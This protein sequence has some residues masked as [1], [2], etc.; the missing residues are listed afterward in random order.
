[1]T[2]TESKAHRR[3]RFWS[4]VL[5]TLALV[6]AG[7]V[8]TVPAHAADGDYVGQVV[9]GTDNSTWETYGGTRIL[10]KMVTD[11]PYNALITGPQFGGG[12]A[13]YNWSIEEG[14]L[15]TGLFYSGENTPSVTI[16]GTPEEAEEFEFVLV[17]DEGEVRYRLQ[18]SGSVESGKIAT[19]TTVDSVD[20]HSA[21]SVSFSA[22]VIAADSSEI[23]GGTVQFALSGMPIGGPVAVA[24]GGVATLTT[25]VDAAFGGDRTITAHYSGDDTFASSSGEKLVTVY[26]GDEV[27]GVVS[28]NGVPQE[29]LTVR[30]IPSDATTT[31]STVTLVDGSYSFEVPVASVDDANRRYTITA[32]FDG[33]TERSW[34]A[35]GTQDGEDATGP[36]NWDGS[37]HNIVLALPPVWTD[38]TIVTPRRGSAYTSDVAAVGGTVTYSVTAG[39]LP[40]GLSLGAATGIIEGTPDCAAAAHLGCTYS[41]TVTADNGYG[42]ATHVFSGDILEPGVPPTW[43]PDSPTVWDLQ[44]TI[45]FSGGVEAEG[46]PAILYTVTGGGLPAGLLLDEATG[47]LTGT[48]ACAL[49]IGIGDPCEYSVTVTATN[50]YGSVDRTF[51]GVIA[52]RPAIDLV[53]EFAA[54]TPIDL[55]ESTISGGG[56]QVGSTYTLEMFSTPVLLYTDIIDASGGFTWRVGIPVGTPP[57]A[58]R[59]LLTG[60]A[61]DGTVLTAEAWFT[62]L[63]DGTIGAISYSGPVAMPGLASTGVDVT[64]PLTSAILLTLIGLGLLRR[65]RVAE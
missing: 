24:A 45:P 28:I 36:T 23:T 8:A 27:G 7:T 30:L 29:G 34:N 37:P 2:S 15:P 35:A 26:A 41:F 58:H 44:E 16:S 19:T 65:R 52:A 55:A 11:L 4:V 49:P 59:L 9:E 57:G 51:A 18:F 46:D 1:M 42:V 53:L 43:A 12:T 31:V 3:P 50:D 56:L 40:L 5:T 62:L 48:P 32:T 13:T 20:L 22:T 47:A 10:P 63:A 38:T 17:A 64:A 39:A 25:A 14:S 33:G 21:S 61:P 60:V 6:L 54:G